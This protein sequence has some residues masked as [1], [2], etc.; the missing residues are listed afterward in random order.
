MTFSEYAQ[1][2]AL[3]VLAVAIAWALG[4]WVTPT[5]FGGPIVMGAIAIQWFAIALVVE[6]TKGV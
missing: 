4:V 1:A 3:L 2:I 5:G 6:R